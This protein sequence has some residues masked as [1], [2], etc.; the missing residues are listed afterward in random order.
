MNTN[1]IVARKNKST[2]DHYE[3]PVLAADKAIK[4]M[5]ADGII[6]TDEVIYEPCCG[7]GNIIK[8]LKDNGVVNVDGSDIQ[9]ADFIAGKKEVDLWDLNDGICDSIVTNPPYNKELTSGEMLL[10]LQKIAKSTVC[11]L[12]NVF[13]LSSKRRK[14]LLESAHLRHIYVYSDRITFFEYGK[15]KPKNGGMKMFVWLCFDKN[16]TGKPTLSWI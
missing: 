6:A 1:S 11:I 16:Y 4:A 15:D 5:L 8:A 14:E 10:K 12:V 2:F 7:S 9:D 3:T 13:Y